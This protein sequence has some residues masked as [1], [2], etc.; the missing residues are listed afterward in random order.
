[1]LAGSGIVLSIV[2]DTPGG[3]VWLVGGLVLAWIGNAVR[4]KS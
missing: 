3:R 2:G 4:N 1:M